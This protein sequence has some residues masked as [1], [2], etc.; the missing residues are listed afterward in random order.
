VSG[1]D[2]DGR[3]YFTWVSFSDPDGNGW[4]LQEIKQRL[5]GRERED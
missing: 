2:P 5:P 4:L 1:P 3:S